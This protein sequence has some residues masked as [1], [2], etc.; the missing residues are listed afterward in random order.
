MLKRLISVE[1]A[2]TA[3]TLPLKQW[4]QFRST[5]MLKSRPSWTSSTS[6][7][8]RPHETPAQLGSSPTQGAQDHLIPSDSV[9]CMCLIFSR[10]HYQGSPVWNMYA[11]L[12][13]STL[14]TRHQARQQARE[15]KRKQTVREM[16]S[17][18][19]TSVLRIGK[20]SKG[21]RRK[22]LTAWR[23]GGSGRLQG[24]GGMNTGP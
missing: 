4:E 22:E 17:G 14:F 24:R 8:K 10:S 20:H 19:H 5:I 23:C 9:F 12:L 21:T 16:E 6:G 15:G 7:P 3:L 18:K 2:H 1:A 11:A 13:L